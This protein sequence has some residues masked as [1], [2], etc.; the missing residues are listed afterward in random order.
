MNQNQNGQCSLEEYK[1]PVECLGPVESPR[2]LI[3][4]SGMCFSSVVRK[5][6][7]LHGRKYKLLNFFGKVCSEFPESV[8][9]VHL[10]ICILCQGNWGRGGGWIKYLM[11]NH[12]NS[13]GGGKGGMGE[14]AKIVII[15]HAVGSG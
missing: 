7:L 10:S 13:V 6:N 14:E 3:D 1:R 8:E 4:C 9:V 12:L 2:P 11:I 15:N 5:C